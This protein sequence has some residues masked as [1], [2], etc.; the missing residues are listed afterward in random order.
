V[1]IN[2]ESQLTTDEAVLARDIARERF[3]AMLSDFDY[4]GEGAETDTDAACQEKVLA[5]IAWRQ[6]VTLVLTGRCI[7]ETGVSG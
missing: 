6:A 4:R 7:L 1:P 3:G 5:V 2:R